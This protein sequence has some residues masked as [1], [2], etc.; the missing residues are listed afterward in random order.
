MNKS[1]L[2]KRGEQEFES[3]LT[4]TDDK[5]YSVNSSGIILENP[6]SKAKN[7][8]NLPFSNTSPDNSEIIIGEAKISAQEKLKGGV[9]KS[10]Q[11]S[12]I[13]SPQKD[14]RSKLN[15]LN[16][17]SNQM[18]N[19]VP[20]KASEDDSQAL[21]SS[22][23]HS[24]GKSNKEGSIEPIDS[25]KKVMAATGRMKAG[26]KNEEVVDVNPLIKSG[27][28]AAIDRGH[29]TVI[30]DSS[31]NTSS[32]IE[33][34]KVETSLQGNDTKSISK[35]KLSPVINL[36][37]GVTPKTVN[38][39]GIPVTDIG[40]GPSIEESEIQAQSKSS[41]SNHK[42]KL[43]GDVKE[44]KLGKAG[45]IT[46]SPAKIS[47][48]D[49]VPVSEK[50]AKT[51]SSPGVQIDDGDEERAMSILNKKLYNPR[52]AFSNFRENNALFIPGVRKSA[53]SSLE[54]LSAISI[55]KQLS[56]FQSTG[57]RLNTKFRTKG[58]PLSKLGLK[59][60]V[61]L[62]QSSLI[63]QKVLQNSYLAR[64]ESPGSADGKSILINVENNSVTSL[65]LES[66][67]REF[68]LPKLNT[69]FTKNGVSVT[70]SNLPESDPMKFS[71]K[72]LNEE[73]NKIQLRLSPKGLGNI[74]IDIHQTGKSLY[75]KIYVESAEVMRILQD[76]LPELKENLSQQ[77]LNLE[78][79][80]ISAR[81]DEGHH[82]RSLMNGERFKED[83]QD[84]NSGSAQSPETD[85]PLEVLGRN[86]VR[87]TSPYSTVEYL[88]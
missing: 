73:L 30:M 12:D 85:V 23:G 25:I 68:S 18:K 44:T 37:K 3:L 72:A 27:N 75:T 57:K 6:P 53:I 38:P 19:T 64:N 84:K 86:Q 1:S 2:N 80:N 31:E 62:K 54:S 36:D 87:A 35:I 9:I 67:V 74:T 42:L 8:L 10:T 33:N 81:R 55:N 78:E 82:Q 58:K 56:D 66:E 43:E 17:A 26:E 46:R 49:V 21:S 48:P 7:I 76:S 13:I 71:I 77:G 59:R 22:R 47:V 24:K 11:K 50:A 39:G 83:R 65:P 29:R 51:V 28:S 20:V 41:I 40:D 79:A 63:N 60:K 32:R 5:L 15:S 88:V 45:E 4:N 34:G 69:T 61:R 52:H 14:T 16:F 70:H